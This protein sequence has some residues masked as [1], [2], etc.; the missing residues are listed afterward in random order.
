[1]TETNS[2]NILA[3]KRATSLAN[4]LGFEINIGCDCFEISAN[5]KKFKHYVKDN[6][7]A[8]V[9]TV[10]ECLAFLK[11]FTVSQDYINLTK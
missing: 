1:M 2:R 6:K 3:W 10:E 9:H 11:G 7:L 4:D 8:T 5:P